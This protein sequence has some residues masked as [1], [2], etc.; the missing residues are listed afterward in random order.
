MAGFSARLL[1]VTA[2]CALA[3]QEDPRVA[4]TAV[5]VEIDGGVQGTPDDEQVRHLPIGPSCYSRPR[6]KGTY[7][8]L[9][10][11]F[12]VTTISQ[13]HGGP[14]ILKIL[15]VLPLLREKYIF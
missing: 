5:R 1:L 10:P 8:K 9:T 3:S 7:L 6:L 15:L 12:E 2:C 11:R 13:K 4:P 14:Q